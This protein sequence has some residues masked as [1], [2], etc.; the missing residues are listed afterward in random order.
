MQLHY[1]LKKIGVIYAIVVAV[2]IFVAATFVLYQVRSYIYER[3]IDE[4][5]RSLDSKIQVITRRVRF[6]NRIAQKLASQTAVRDI[7]LLGNAE[8]AERWSRTTREQIPDAVGVTLFSPERGILGRP[9]AQNVGPACIADLGKLINGVSVPKPPIHNNDPGLAHYDLTAEIKRFDETL[10]ILF[11]SISTQTLKRAV[12]DMTGV[13]E[14]IVLHN[15]HGDVFY[16]SV[17][18][19]SSA[20]TPIVFHK[21][22]LETDWQIEYSTDPPDLGSVYVTFGAAALATAMI[23]AVLAMLLM[24]WMVRM[25]SR[26]MRTVRYLLGQLARGIAPEQKQQV[27]ITEM[28]EVVGAIHQIK[29]NSLESITIERVQFYG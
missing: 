12:D 23:A 15:A 19:I 22:V 17:V 2:L 9:A 14:A 29:Y 20:T 18:N 5:D 26:E 6:Y 21:S 27:K 4:I 3:Q 13:G 24:S 16:R 1:S 25:I 7:L 28:K 11:I 8:Q 10:G